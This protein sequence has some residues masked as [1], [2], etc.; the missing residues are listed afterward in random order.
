MAEGYLETISVNGITLQVR[1]PSSDKA[2][3]EE[4]LRQDQYQLHALKR[5]GV[6]LN[7]VV[8]VGAHIGCFSLL[9]NRLWPNC[10][11]W[12]Y[13]PDP[14]NYRL[15]QTQK[16]TNVVVFQAAVVGRAAHSTVKFQTANRSWSPPNTV[17]GHLSEGGDVEVNAISIAEALLVAP[18]DMLKLDCEG[19]ECEILEAA[20]LSKV[21]YVRG[22]Y[23]EQYAK[24]ALE[25]VRAA[26]EPTHELVVQGRGPVG[27]FFA[28]RR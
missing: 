2:T 21:L 22:E 23:H 14:E 6:E 20:D 7:T 4:V 11:V 18:I 10:R 27:M 17:E 25:R 13:E 26:L 16:C 19:A 9:V 8:D 1:E 3:V 12:A 15:L 24:C 28:A 5:T